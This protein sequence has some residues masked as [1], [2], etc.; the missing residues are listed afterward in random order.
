VL[1]T[2]TGRN[3]RELVDS[4]GAD[5]LIDWQEF[6]AFVLDTYA[7]VRDAPRSVEAARDRY[8]DWSD[9]T[10]WFSM[11]VSGS[12]SPYRR[13]ISVD[14][15]RLRTAVDGMTSLDDDI[16]YPVGTVFAGEHLDDGGIRE[17]TFMV[18]RADGLWDYFAYGPDGRPT[19]TIEHDPSDLNVPT[20]C[21]GCHL[22]SRQFEPERSFPAEARPGPGGE[23][24][25]YVDPAV[26][27]SDIAGRIREHLKRSDRIL[28]LYVTI[29]LSELRLRARADLDA[30]ERST[31]ERLFDN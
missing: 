2:D 24:R 9:S 17:T 19:R 22:G 13:R 27:S 20:Q 15:A 30:W 7:D 3:V 6:E 16:I 14:M 31:L 23:R 11:S 29:Y 18:K 25:V 21:I 26:R 12:M 28:G 8:G 4:A 10:R 5:G 1:S